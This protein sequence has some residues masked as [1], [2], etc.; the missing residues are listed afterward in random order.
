MEIPGNLDDIMAIAADSFLDNDD[1]NPRS[2]KSPR[3]TPPPTPS[4]EELL[5]FWKAHQSQRE[6]GAGFQEYPEEARATDEDKI[7]CNRQ[8]AEAAVEAAA[9]SSSGLVVFLESPAMFTTKMLCNPPY[10]L[11]KSRMRCPQVDAEAF[12]KMREEDHVSH[13]KLHN[14]LLEC[15]E[16]SIGAIWMDY[17]CTFDGNASTNIYPH[18]DIR[19]VVENKLIR[20]GG[21][22]FLTVSLRAYDSAE[23]IALG[24]NLS[25]ILGKPIIT[26]TYANMYFVG[27]RV[28]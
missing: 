23:K 2:P 20:P 26:K 4:H 22:L 11:H 14:F 10:N 9:D 21:F 27:F 8:F 3:V 18:E 25:R 13:Q 1:D 7:W 19:V 12:Q 28:N 15:S 16:G 5:K 17:C 24:M 6:G